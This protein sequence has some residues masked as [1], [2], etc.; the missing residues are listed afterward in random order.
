ALD[1]THTHTH[2]HITNGR[3]DRRAAAQASTQ[4]LSVPYSR[5]PSSASLRSARSHSPRPTA[6][7]RAASLA[8]T[9]RAPTLAS[10]RS[11]VGPSWGAPCARCRAA[12]PSWGRFAGS[13]SLLRVKAAR[14]FLPFRQNKKP[15]RVG[16]LRF[17]VRESYRIDI[18]VLARVLWRWA[19]VCRLR[20]CASDLE[21]SSFELS[22][23]PFPE[24]MRRDGGD[25]PD[26]LEHVVHTGLKV[27]GTPLE[28]ML[29]APALVAWQDEAMG[30]RRHLGCLTV[31]GVP[32][33]VN[34]TLEVRF[35]VAKNSTLLLAF[36]MP[37]KLRPSRRESPKHMYLV[38]PSEQLRL[39]WAATNSSS[40]S[41][42]SETR[43]CLEPD[44]PV[45]HIRLDLA[46]PPAVAMP[47][48]RR[49]L[50]RPI[51][52]APSGLLSC[53]HSLTQTMQLDV[54]LSDADDQRTQACLAALA[55]RMRLTPLATPALDLDATYSAGAGGIDLWNDYPCEPG[56]ADA[57]KGPWNP[58]APPPAYDEV[59]GV[60]AAAAEGACEEPKSS[61]SEKI[62]VGWGGAG[63]SSSDEGGRA[64]RCSDVVRGVLPAE[65]ARREGEGEGD[66]HG[67]GHG[68]RDA[69][70]VAGADAAV[71]E[72]R[73]MQSQSQ[74][75]PPP[76]RPR[77]RKASAALSDVDIDNTEKR[78]KYKH[79]DN[80]NADTD[81]N[82]DA[83]AGFGAS[84]PSTDTDRIGYDK[85]TRSA[86]A[87]FV[88]AALAASAT[89]TD[90]ATEE[91]ESPVVAQPQ[92]HPRAASAPVEQQEHKH[93][94]D[95]RPQPSP[96]PLH[97]AQPSTPSTPQT[98]YITDLTLLLLRAWSLDPAAHRDF[99]LPA[100]LELGTLA[101][102]DDA[103]AFAAL[104]GECVLR[105]VER[106]AVARARGGG[107]AGRLADQGGGGAA[108]Q[109]KGEEGAKA[110]EV[111]EE[112]R[113]WLCEFVGRR[114][115]TVECV[116]E[117]LVR[118]WGAVAAVQ[119]E[120]MGMEEGPKWEVVRVWRAECLALGIVVGGGER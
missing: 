81:T 108:R 40:D 101:R 95:H 117:A 30:Q 77:K 105:L 63:S 46:R 27:S 70:E 39:S 13:R 69:E 38:I 71:E 65:F 37:V 24:T 9:R 83:A 49:K 41:I 15:G 36:H 6:Q 78:D 82:T 4:R 85:Y 99:L 68:V 58:L 19:D 20:S 51:V 107:A 66:G 53:L 115:D 112:L 43:P 26:E 75:Q 35:D 60:G 42:H 109:G 44:T 16:C 74:S 89:E 14:S 11:P 54:Y 90:V 47:A 22:H 84:N 97:P 1:S 57:G 62:V 106:G 12:L 5:Y 56:I 92:A 64:T 18:V 102:S 48:L 76:A 118:V 88:D 10:L 28:T 21:A 110:E 104:R 120:G 79:K 119:A 55:A 100:L 52:G 45:I 50:Q 73:D 113:S 32:R 7:R 114:A 59:V 2:T 8:R 29:T 17:G 98:P 67:H 93:E 23:L 72:Q 25:G 80:N 34:F 91:S 86:A 87:F 94:H 111:V 3:T 31:N 103:E 96:P 116:F 33:R 61:P